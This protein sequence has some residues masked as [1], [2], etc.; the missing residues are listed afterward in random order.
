MVTEKHKL[1]NGNERHAKGRNIGLDIAFGL[2]GCRVISVKF[3]IQHVHIHW[4][5]HRVVDN[6]IPIKHNEFA[7]DLKFLELRCR[8]TSSLQSL[9]HSENLI[10][11][12]QHMNENYIVR[13]VLRGADIGLRCQL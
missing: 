12:F 3:Y 13:I 2:H 11:A 1:F 7:Q 8:E 9:S 4:G 5:S 10:A 6:K